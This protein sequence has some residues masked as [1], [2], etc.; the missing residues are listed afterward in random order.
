MEGK[1]KNRKEDKRA[2]FVSD[3]RLMIGD[4][5]WGRAERVGKKLA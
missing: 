4:D 1:N 3:V 2:G 5:C